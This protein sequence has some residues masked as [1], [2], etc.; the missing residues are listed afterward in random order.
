MPFNALFLDP[1]SVFPS[2]QKFTSA[3]CDHLKFLHTFSRASRAEQGERGAPPS[4]YRDTRQRAECYE[5][6]T[7][8]PLSV[9]VLC[10]DKPVQATKA[11]WKQPD[12][13]HCR[14][15]EIYVKSR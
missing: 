15:Y 7:R 10:W 4:A 9:K 12:E 6:I 14:T 8:T 5:P 2:I 3:I 13:N 11:V 1:L